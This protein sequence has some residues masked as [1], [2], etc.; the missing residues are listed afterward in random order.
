MNPPSPCPEC[1]KQ[2]AADSFVNNGG[3]TGNFDNRGMLLGI[4]ESTFPYLPIVQVIKPDDGLTTVDVC[5][6]NMRL[7]GPDDDG[8]F[9]TYSMDEGG[10]AFKPDDVEI[11]V[12]HN[13]VHIRLLEARGL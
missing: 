9:A 5:Y 8:D 1:R 11:T 13:V 12:R 2:A 4:L 7:D 3:L 6:Q 10:F